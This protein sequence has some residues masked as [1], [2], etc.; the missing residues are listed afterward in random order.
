MLNDQMSVFFTQLCPP[1]CPLCLLTSPI[2][3]LGT[4]VRLSATF[5]FWSCNTSAYFIK[6]Q[7][8]F[9]KKY[10]PSIETNEI[11]LCIIHW[12]FLFPP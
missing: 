10:R 12:G 2:H 7:N 11:F 8:S 3:L 9:A 6:E 5:K 1:L 4:H